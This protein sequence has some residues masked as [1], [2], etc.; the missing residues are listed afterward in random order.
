[1][2]HH[3]VR[4]VVD[5]QAVLTYHIMQTMVLS[6]AQQWSR[7]LSVSDY[8][9]TLLANR[10]LCLSTIR[11]LLLNVALPHIAADTQVKMQASGCKANTS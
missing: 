6:I 2:W 8:L 1:M 4:C 10:S 5:L 7:P 9:G 11:Y 3:K